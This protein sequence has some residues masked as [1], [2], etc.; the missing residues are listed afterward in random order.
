M[1]KVSFLTEQS[2]KRAP[3]PEQAGSVRKKPNDGEERGALVTCT[4]LPPIHCEAYLSSIPHLI[5]D[6]LHGRSI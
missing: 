6:L 2:W 4:F 3:L 1:M 5:D